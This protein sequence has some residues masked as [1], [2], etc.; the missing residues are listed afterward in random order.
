MYVARAHSVIPEILINKHLV[1]PNRVRLFHM[2]AVNPVCS[3]H[4]L[5]CKYIYSVVLNLQQ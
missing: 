2:F 4:Y 3:N 5:R 1:L